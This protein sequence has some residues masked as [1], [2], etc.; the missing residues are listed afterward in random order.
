MTKLLSLCMSLKHS[1]DSGGILRALLHMAGSIQ[2]LSTA[3][4]H[5]YTKTWAFW[6][7]KHASI[8]L[9]STALADREYQNHRLVVRLS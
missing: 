1:K 2:T 7:S 5:L 6:A 3:S 8:A 9:K 4:K